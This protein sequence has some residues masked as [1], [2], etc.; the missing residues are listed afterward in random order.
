MN[1][2]THT[3][4]HCALALL[5]AHSTLSI[6]SQEVSVLQQLPPIFSHS[7]PKK[8]DWTQA[9]NRVAELGGWQFYA[10]QAGGHGNHSAMDHSKHSGHSEHQTESEMDH[11]T[12]SGHSGHQTE[13]EMDHSRHSG[14]ATPK[15]TVPQPA[16]GAQ[17]EHHH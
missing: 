8:L 2:Y 17:H 14:H 16:A 1:S 10:Q 7:E 11:S 13:S 4:L 9:N 6:A 5:A 12:H 15:R 3:A